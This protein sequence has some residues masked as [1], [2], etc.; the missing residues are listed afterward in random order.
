MNLDVLARGLRDRDEYKRM[1]DHGDSPRQG[2]RDGRGN[3][4]Q[5]ALQDF[6]EWFLTV[7][8]DQVRFSAVMF[9]L[10]RL[11]E[12]Y[13]SLVQDVSDDKRAPDLVSAVLRHGSL[14][15]GEAGHVLK[16]SERTARSTLAG[17]DKKGFLRSDSPK[18]PVRIAFPLDYRERLFPNLFTDAEVV[19]PEVP[20]MR[21]GR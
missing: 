20:Q 18:S 13:R 10:G 15:R 12:R 3:L 6:S 17:L 5:A 21:L 19:A 7:S 14:P 16:T 11:E 9:D 8:L 4:S 1:M 2:E